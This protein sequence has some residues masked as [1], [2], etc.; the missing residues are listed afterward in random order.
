M[1]AASS[2]DQI[3]SIARTVE[4]A[5]ILF[6]AIRGHDAQDSTSLTVGVLENITPKKK[7]G[8][9]RS[10]LGKGV[11][12]DIMVLFVETEKK[13]VAQGYEIVDVELPHLP[14]SLAVYYIINPAEVSTNLARF[15]GIRYGTRIDGENI[16]EV[17]E[18][19]RAQGFGPETRRRILVGSF[20]LSAGY[21]DAYYRKARA[22][23]ELIRQDFVT[24]F[25]TVDAIL[26]PTTP[27]PAFKLGSH[28]TDPVAMYL[29]DIFTVPIN[30]AGVPAMSVPVGTVVRD[31][32]TLPVG[33][34]LIG[35]HRHENVLFEVAKH[36]AV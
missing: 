2:L 20:V 15:D 12:E 11:D 26:L 17:Y 13:L 35:N 1:A 19:S 29:E 30:L 16:T 9:P 14:Y 34:Q 6:E 22:V 24:T 7:I 33:L 5:Q 23:R 21:A 25:E 18:Q 10:F 8:V 31:G 28:T 3:G 4:D 32:A 36:I 27:T